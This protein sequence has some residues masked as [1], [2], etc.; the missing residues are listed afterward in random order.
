MSSSHFSPRGGS[1]HV[2]AAL[3]FATTLLAAAAV[4]QS[5]TPGLNALALEWIRGEYRAPLICEIDG[6]P[7]RALRRVLVSPGPRSAPTPVNRL[8]LFDLDAPQGT[9]CHDETG[10][11]QPNA[12]GSLALA[13]EAR[14]PP[15]T[16]QRDFAAALRRNGGFQFQIRAGLLRLGGPGETADALRKVDFSGGTAEIRMVERG[17]DAFRR[18][19][20]FGERRKLTLILEAPDETR[21]RLD[22]VQFGLR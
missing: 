22:L 15:D 5:P 9:R 19:A 21:L 3:A 1:V 20:D 18:L 12:I 17:S 10:V 11:D 6:V 4:A 14:S 13:L 16:A 7:Y 8:T 2:G